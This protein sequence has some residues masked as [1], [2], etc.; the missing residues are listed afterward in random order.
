MRSI[1]PLVAVACLLTIASLG[2]GEFDPT[3]ASA[4]PKATGAAFAGA[5]VA[6]LGDGATTNRPLEKLRIF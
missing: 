5:G 1:L 2:R 6:A 3:G 4:K